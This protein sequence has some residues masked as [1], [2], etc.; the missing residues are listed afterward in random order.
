VE[1]RANIG[2]EAKFD[3]PEQ[4]KTVSTGQAVDLEITTAF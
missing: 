4:S 2:K 3:I 1:D